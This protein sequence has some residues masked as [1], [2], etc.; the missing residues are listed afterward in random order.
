MRCRYFPLTLAAVVA[1]TG[2]QDR[3]SGVATSAHN[4]PTD[5]DLV[6]SFLGA[7]PMVLASASFAAQV[8]VCNPGGGASGPSTLE[9]RG[10]LDAIADATDAYVGMLAVP[11]LDPGSC[12]T[13]DV[14]ATAPAA[15]GQYQLLAIADAGGVIV[16]D[17]ED[18]VSSRALAVGF[19]SQLRVEIQR[20]TGRGFDAVALV[21]LCN[22]GTDASRD[23]VDV[24]ASLDAVI[25]PATDPWIGSVFVPLLPGTCA[26]EW[27]YPSGPYL[28]GRYHLGAAVY[29]SDG[30]APQLFSGP[31]ALFEDGAGLE[32]TSFEI[33]YDADLPY[34][35][36]SFEVCNAGYDVSGPSQVF[37]YESS[38]PDFDPW[39]AYDSGAV[40]LDGIRP[41]E[42][43]SGRTGSLY[44]YGQPP[45]WVAARLEGP[46]VNFSHNELIVGP[47]RWDVGVDLV[48]SAIE[49]PSVTAGPFDARLSVC[50]VGIQASPASDV[51]L[52]LSADDRLTGSVG[53]AGG[54]DPLLAIV[55]VSPLVAGECAAVRA[56]VTGPSSGEYRLGAIVDEAGLITEASEDNALLGPA[57][58]FGDGADLVVTELVTPSYVLPR[59]TF[60]GGPGPDGRIDGIA[61]VCNRGTSPSESGSVVLEWATDA[62]DLATYASTSVRA[63]VVPALQPGACTPVAVT[64]DV[65]GVPPEGFT[66]VAIGAVLNPAQAPASERVRSNDALSS[67]V[68]GVGPGIDLSVS[69]ELVAQSGGSS[70]VAW[71]VCNFGSEPTSSSE[72]LYLL[73]HERTQPPV[74]GY[75]WY[76]QGTG[77]AHSLP[78]VQPGA[79][80]TGISQV[81][82]YG[83]MG[84]IVGRV[85][86]WDA[87]ADRNPSN[88][89]SA[90]L[91]LGEGSDLVI[92][93]LSAESGAGIES[94]VCNRGVMP[95]YESVVDY[96]LAPPISRPVNS[97]PPSSEWIGNSVVPALSPGACHAA[98]SVMQ[99]VSLSETLEVTAIVDRPDYEWEIREDNN[100]RAALVTHAPICG[101]GVVN[102]GDACDDGNGVSGDGCDAA[103]VIEYC[104]D[105]V[106]Q[107]GLGEACDDGN[108]AGGDGCTA[109]QIDAPVCGDGV[110]GGSEQCDDGNT[111]AG[112]GCDGVCVAEYCGDGV[113]QAGLG[114]ACDDGN[115]AAGDGCTACQVDA[116]VCGDGIVGGGEQCDDGNT[117][118]ADGCSATCVGEISQQP[119]WSNQNG[120]CFNGNYDYVLGYH[121]TPLVDGWIT[122]LGARVSGTKR[123]RLWTRGSF[124]QLAETQ[125]T[126]NYQWSYSQIPPVFVTAGVSYTVGVYLAGTGGTFCS[127]INP[128][129]QTYGDIRIDA[130][131]FQPTSPSNPNAVPSSWT[132]QAM[133]GLAD[134]RFVPVTR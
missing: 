106:L 46:E 36:A 11:A 41:G 85:W 14:A 77:M 30:S 40:Y 1:L 5:P 27:T 6:V 29:P 122:H 118:D 52:Y 61:T 112:D 59:T 124:T 96:Y 81:S 37:F 4:L 105:G 97:L 102:G 76:A 111:V 43:V 94:T 87:R 2:C 74:P 9:L 132:Y 31:Q 109:C 95:S 117:T 127:H 47:R 51:R 91:H 49:A 20:G 35:L 93:A 17:D 128:L 104:G 99:S 10:S 25:D 19:R 58:G 22:D 53:D 39:P 60:T 55:P 107:S 119:W 33:S 66:A 56:I 83:T 72:A 123:V 42:C 69:L 78:T 38:D 130:A 57:I 89:A 131:A 98:V 28:S 110:V 54:I 126:D 114:E 73:F 26:S 84:T 121:F 133:N 80:L 24:F 75:P 129:P 68:L 70:D 125:V 21:R 16:E 113:L 86:S 82:T 48:V 63:A 120:Q 103:C 71:S 34:P 3:A 8:T 18:N 50:N 44:I 79:C 12:F 90:P 115:G 64:M 23:A 32:L 88:D 134:V 92:E 67:G 45:V 15:D 62:R 108:G 101:D 65:G 100:R 116:P 13:R 7:P